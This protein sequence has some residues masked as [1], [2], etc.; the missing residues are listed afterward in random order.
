MLAADAWQ[1]HITSK[2]FVLMFPLVSTAYLLVVNLD[3][4]YDATVTVVV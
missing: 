3:Y 4:E 1:R 2:W